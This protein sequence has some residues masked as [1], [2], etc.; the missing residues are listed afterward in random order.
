[1]GHFAISGLQFDE[2]VVTAYKEDEDYPELVGTWLLFDKKPAEPRVKLT[3]QNPA[4]TVE[5]R[6]GPKAAVLVGA[7]TDANTHAPIHVCAGF[8]AVSAPDFNTAYPIASHY[9]LLIPAD[10]DINLKVWWDGYRP[11]YYPG[12]D[13]NV[14][15]TPLRLKPGEEKIINIQLQP[16]KSINNAKCGIN[17]LR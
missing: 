2:Y 9:R 11:W 10:A 14:A 13:E 4:A 1:M 17:I 8:K 6:L 3:A 7:I 5:I 16:D 15:G 12:T